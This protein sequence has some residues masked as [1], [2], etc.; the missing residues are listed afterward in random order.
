[1][2]TF[3]SPCRSQKTPT[4]TKALSTVANQR[5]F[6]FLRLPLELCIQIYEL[7]FPEVSVRRLHRAKLT[8]SSPIYRCN[9]PGDS[10]LYTC[11]PLSR[12]SR[13]SRAACTTL[14]LLNHS[15]G[16]LPVKML[17]QRMGQGFCQ[18]LK[19]LRVS[20]DFALDLRYQTLT[21]GW[22]QK[23]LLHGTFPSLQRIVMFGTPSYYPLD[24]RSWLREF[25]HRFDR[26][27]LGLTF[28]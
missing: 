23:D 20:F 22:G 7:V 24:E 6:P 17:Q 12:E 11:R 8:L 3:N 15:Y 10:L 16:A 5:S 18:A 21:T 2:F 13:A 14:I 1:M 9:A 26:P 19:V 4:L 25:R 28:E 27:D